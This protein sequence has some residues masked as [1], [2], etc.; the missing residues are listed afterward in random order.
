MPQNLDSNQTSFPQKAAGQNSSL[1]DTTQS[2]PAV[3][4]DSLSKKK[5]DFKADDSIKSKNT[6]KDSNQLV[7]DSNQLI[8]S[9]SRI[10]YNE[11]KLK[12]KDSLQ[13]L[14]D[15]LNRDSINTAISNFRH[16][17]NIAYHKSTKVGSYQEGIPKNNSYQNWS[18]IILILCFIM[19]A[20]SKAKYAKRIDL[21]IKSLK[22]WK[23]G[24]QVIRYERVYSHPTNIILLLIFLFSTSLFIQKAL[25][26]DTFRDLSGLQLFFSIACLFVGIYLLKIL[27]LLSVGKIFEIS[28]FTNEYIF[29]FLLFLKLTGVLLL[30]ISIFYLYSS[31][32]NT[33]SIWL[34]ICI[35][36]AAYFARII[37]AFLIG[38]QANEKLYTI[39]LYLC[40]LEILPSL[41]IGKFIKDMLIR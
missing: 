20:F 23:F 22:S 41:V 35:L 31:V 28:E 18:I 30:P 36:I 15:S 2:L 37:R 33:L 34:G 29:H 38:L 25:L 39:F 3:S 10:P 21:L 26:V 24:K 32:G 5:L 14:Q 11:K 16:S 27:I 8:N 17:A 1:L 9:R 4:F 13:A 12:K 7:K 40:T 19:L 6:V